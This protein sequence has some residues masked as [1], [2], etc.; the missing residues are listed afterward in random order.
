[1][2]NIFDM[3]S[4]LATSSCTEGTNTITIK[5]PTI[6]RVTNFNTT[7]VKTFILD[8]MRA[9]E[10]RQPVIPIICDSYGG[11]VYSLLAMVDIINNARVPVATI[12]EGK[13]MSCGAVLASCGTKGYRYMTDNATMMIHDVASGSFG[14][15]SELQVKVDEANR[16]NKIAF[17]LLD[18]N[19]GKKKGYFLNILKDKS[20]ADWFLSP[21]DA[22]KHGLIDKVGLPHFKT[23]VKITQELTRK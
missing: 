21:K 23:K 20:R 5:P 14:K 6:I 16:L 15:I 9:H 17:D 18:K 8:M 4:N 7:S 3:D 22:K 12:I 19:A 1:M 10:T 11:E 2:I 13:A